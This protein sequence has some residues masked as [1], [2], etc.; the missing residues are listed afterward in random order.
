[1]LARPGARNHAARASRRRFSTSTS[2]SEIAPATAR[3]MGERLH[4]V[5]IGDDESA[6]ATLG[7]RT[8]VVWARKWVAGH[9]PAD[10]AGKTIGFLRFRWRS[11]R[12]PSSAWASW[13]SKARRPGLRGF[14]RHLVFGRGG[15][16]STSH[17]APDRDRPLR[18]ASLRPRA[19]NDSRRNRAVLRREGPQAARSTPSVRHYL[20]GLGPGGG[21]AGSRRSTLQQGSFAESERLADCKGRRSRAPIFMSRVIAPVAMS[22]GKG[23]QTER[24]G[25]D[26]TCRRPGARKGGAGS[27][28]TSGY[29]GSRPPVS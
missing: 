22:E 26:R 16:L 3:P 17:S 4:R 6:A 12:F 20:L 28:G 8:G 7:V 18:R 13:R 1:V 14:S 23:S 10:L 25:A 15:K 21:R 19:D 11:S 5:L 9:R 27:A 29:G 24:Q 2:S